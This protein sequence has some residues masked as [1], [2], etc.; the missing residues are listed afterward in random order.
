MKMFA[1]LMRISFNRERIWPED[2]AGGF[3]AFVMLQ[4]YVFGTC[5]QWE[6]VKENMGLVME[7]SPSVS[8]DFIR[9]L[10]IDLHFFFL[11][12]V[13]AIDLI[14]EL[15][16]REGEGK[17]AEIVREYSESFEVFSRDL[18]NISRLKEFLS[19]RFM[20]DFGQFE[21]GS[22]QL[23]GKRFALSSQRVE[24]ITG[25]YERVLKV[26]NEKIRSDGPEY[27]GAGG[28]FHTGSGRNTVLGDR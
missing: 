26:L 6:R 9:S 28:S 4:Q 17:M 22:V 11:S 27:S 24:G 5:K 18:E 12:A 8:T 21:E 2:P 10:F 19:G 20:A 23:G 3:N 16:E 14:R 13:K 1:D 7:E 15:A 25:P